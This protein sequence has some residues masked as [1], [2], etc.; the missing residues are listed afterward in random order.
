MPRHRASQ[1]GGPLADCCIRRVVSFE[2]FI[3]QCCA[4][5]DDK[6]VVR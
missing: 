1:G 5:I 2:E 4:D 6:G 3:Q